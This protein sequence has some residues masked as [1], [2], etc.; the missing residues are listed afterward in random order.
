MNNKK[1]KVY[2]GVVTD[3]G[4]MADDEAKE[5]YD[6]IYDKRVDKIKKDIPD[7]YTNHRDQTTDISDKV[8][9]AFAKVHVETDMKLEDVINKYRN[10]NTPDYKD[11]KDMDG[12][13]DFFKKVLGGIDHPLYSALKD[14]EDKD[15]VYMGLVNL[16]NSGRTREGDKSAQELI[17][18]F[19][20]DPSN[21]E[22]F[23]LIIDRLASTETTMYSHAIE[24]KYLTD[25]S[26]E[27][28]IQ[29]A[30]VYSDMVNKRTMHK[31]HLDHYA[32]AEKMPLNKMLETLSEQPNKLAAMHDK[33]SHSKLYD[34]KKRL[35][36]NTGE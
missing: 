1:R 12:V 30:G 6:D 16:L 7:S 21:K 14:E 28:K 32:I 36:E 3:D 20:R 35:E 26:D 10:Y 34:E 22:I 9:E 5:K 15:K 24:S 33:Y 2:I 25:F 8:K 27:E 19:K 18:E 11:I 17:E 31:T 4:Y 13:M 29:F 23:K